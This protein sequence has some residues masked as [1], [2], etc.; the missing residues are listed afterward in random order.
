LEDTKGTGEA[1]KEIVIGQ[2]EFWNSKKFIEGHFKEIQ[3][4]LESYGKEKWFMT[5][6]SISEGKN[7][8]FTKNLEIK[9]LLEKK[10][11]AKF[12]GDIGIT[13]R[14]WLRKEILQKI[15]KS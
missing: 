12:N 4:T 6:P 14:L 3:E 9:S 1:G 2:L 7:Y 15:Q 8:L 10:I 11:G 13:D 5:S